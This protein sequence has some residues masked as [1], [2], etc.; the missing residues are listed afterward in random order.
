M[1]KK[2]N[3]YTKID[4]TATFAMTLA[5]KSHALTIAAP[6]NSIATNVQASGPE[7]TGM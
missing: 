4:Q 7:L 5:A 1:A 2:Y 6:F 3:P